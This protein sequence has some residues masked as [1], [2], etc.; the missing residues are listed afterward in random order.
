MVPLTLEANFT[1]EI[2]KFFLYFIKE[3]MMNKFRCSPQT[4]STGAVLS[5]ILLS[6]TFLNT[7]SAETVV[8]DDSEKW[9]QNY[10]VVPVSEGTEMTRSAAEQAALM[11]TVMVTPAGK[12]TSVKISEAA[13]RR[14][15]QAIEDGEDGKLPKQE[16]ASL[17]NPKEAPGDRVDG[18]TQE[19]VIGVDTRNK[20]NNTKSFP[21]RAAGRIAVGCTG[22][23]IGPRHVLTAGHC[24]YNTS[25]DQWY[26]NLKFS[27]GQNGASRP[28]G[29][30]A[31]KFAISVKGWTKDHQSN[32]D[33]AM[34]VLKSNI[35][36]RTGWMGYGYNNSLPDYNVN[37]NGYPGDKP[38]G[39]QWHSYCNLRAR[40]TYKLFYPCDTFNGMSGSGV[41]VYWP[42]SGTRRI[43][44]IHTNGT[45]GCASTGVNC[46]TRIRSAVFYNL[47]SWKKKY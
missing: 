17:G 9:N 2:N 31:W 27:P 1:N 28:Y 8:F 22:T 30:I 39:T 33:Y 5:A 45:G 41:Y 19:S 35:G 6:A 12:V 23:L 37:I 44:A 13:V 20:V 36:N 29:E 40:W 43:Y 15:I 14:M 10:H 18:M 46:G 47:K 11:E 3:I 24:V 26:S 38:S 34:I 25:T 16:K 42:S 32:Y 7:V 21:F 4:A